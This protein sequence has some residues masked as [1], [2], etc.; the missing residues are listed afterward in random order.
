VEILPPKP[1][2][3]GFFF[4]TGLTAHME[5]AGVCQFLSHSS[6]LFFFS[7]KSE[8]SLQVMVMSMAFGVR[9]PVHPHMKLDKLFYLLVL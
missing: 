2:K 4:G 7:N 6:V 3:Q 9:L 8:K 1:W 5:N